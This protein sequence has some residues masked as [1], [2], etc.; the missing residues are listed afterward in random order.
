[1]NKFTNNFMHALSWLST[2][3]RLK[4]IIQS[5]LLLGLCYVMFNAGRVIEQDNYTKV[6]DKPYPLQP[7][8]YFGG[9]NTKHL[10]HTW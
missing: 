10:I 6:L 4:A 9:L 2:G 1:M 5:L 8:T 7:Q 3:P